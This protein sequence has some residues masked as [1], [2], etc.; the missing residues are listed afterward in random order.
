MMTITKNE[1]ERDAP[2]ILER[3]FSK[4]LSGVLND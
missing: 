2:K 4:F 1:I 3:E